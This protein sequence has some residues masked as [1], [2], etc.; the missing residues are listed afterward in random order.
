MNKLKS[1]A[2]ALSLLLVAMN[3]LAGTSGSGNQATSDDP[4]T[5]NSPPLPSQIRLWEA[6]AKGFATVEQTGGAQHTI[7]NYG[8]ASIIIDERIMIMSPSPANPSEDIPGIDDEAQDGVLTQTYTVPIGGS[9]DYNYGDNVLLQGGL[10]PAWW[11]T[12]DSEYTNAVPITLGGEILPYDLW[13]VVDYPDDTVVQ[14]GLQYVSATQANIW[15]YIREN[16]TLVIGKLPL[17]EEIGNMGD[18]VDI[19]LDITNIGFQTASGVVVTDLIP[20]DYSYDPSS[21]TQ[22]PSAILNNPDGS[23]TLKWNIPQI[24]AAVETG[25][26]EPT[27]YTT[28]NIG[29]KLLTPILDPDIRI[30]LPRAYVD[31]NGDGVDEA[32][33]EEPLLETYLVN[34]PPVAIVDDVTIME[35]E[36]AILDGSAS[37]D[38]DQSIGDTIVSYDWD[39]DEDGVIDA[40]GPIVSKEYGDNGEYLVTLT[41]T[42]TYGTTSTD[43]ATVTVE[44]VAPIVDGLPSV[45]IN[46]GGTVSFTGHVTDPGSDDLTVLWSWEYA[47]WCDDSMIYYN[48]GVS[49]DPPLSPDMNPM[50]ITESK[51]CEYGDNGV[52]T[53]TLTVIDDDGGNTTESATVTVGNLDPTITRSISATMDLD[54]GIRVAGSKWSN[55]MLELVDEDG[56]SVQLLEVER[57]PGDPDKNPSVGITSVTLDMTKS[58]KAVV[59]YDPFP[60]DGDAIEGDQGNNGKDKKDNAGNPVWL[61]ICFQDGSCITLHHTFNTQQSKHRGS[62]HWNHVDPWEVELSPHLVGHEFELSA[63]ASDEGSDDLTFDWSCGFQNIHFNDDTGPDPFPSPDGIYPF[64]AEDEVAPTYTGPKTID[65]TVYDDDGGLV[66]ESISI[67]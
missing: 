64:G 36:T 66:S 38:P 1:I 28:V 5:A 6:W 62:E 14:Y 22:T 25:V 11:C 37:Y 4:V 12:E 2:I 60:D 16:P 32:E 26:F 39:T 17:W 41:V 30:F 54:L 42:D 15:T 33:S 35:G 3:V 56:N 67:P 59:T 18:E 27:D 20:S 55:V 21:F 53:V 31:R 40:T 43:N 61:I 29:Y 58:Y 46:E 19:T 13:D 63:E 7:T 48:N 44:N 47:S 23:I 49:P 50:D 34:N 65:L 24:D 9:L 52:Y 51:I 45:T 10:P 57:W 8:L